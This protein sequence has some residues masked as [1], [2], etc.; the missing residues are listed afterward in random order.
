MERE[1][2][3]NKNKKENEVRIE[4]KEPRYGQS[5]PSGKFCTC[6]YSV[7]SVLFLRQHLLVKLVLG[8]PLCNLLLMTC[9]VFLLATSRLI[10]PL[11]VQSVLFL[12]QRL[13]MLLVLG[14]PLCNLLLMT[15]K[16]VCIG[17]STFSVHDTFHVEA[18]LVVVRGRF[19]YRC[20][21]SFPL[22]VANFQ[23]QPSQH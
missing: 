12:G 4:L 3:R 19:P 23:F 9:K 22:D 10:V 8:H 11:S 13:L 2:R 20:L 6:E 16:V 18:P 14:H 17:Y 5:P 15:C 21:R 7:Q 1:H